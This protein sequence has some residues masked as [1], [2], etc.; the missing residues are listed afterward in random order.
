MLMEGH[1]RQLKGKSV[2]LSLRLTNQALRHEDVLGSGC[3]DPL[4]LYFATAWI[5]QP[6]APNVLPR[7]K[8]RLY[9]LDMR[10]AGPQSRSRRRG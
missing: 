7:D 8:S 10:L 1:T 3:I 4:I 2:K 5:L 6:N 9:P